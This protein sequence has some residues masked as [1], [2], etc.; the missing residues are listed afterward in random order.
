MSKVIALIAALSVFTLGGCATFRGLKEDAQSA[1]YKVKKSWPWGKKFT[2]SNEQVRK[3][4]QH[5]RSRGYQAG[6]ADG[7]MGPQTIS[8]LRRYQSANGLTVTGEVDADTLDSL[9]ID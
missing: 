6:T 7:I 9:G 8:A 2:A 1:A 4:Q 5:L 3:A